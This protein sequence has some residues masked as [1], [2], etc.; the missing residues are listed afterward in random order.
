VNELET[1]R[2]IM[3]HALPILT[4][5][6]WPVTALLFVGGLMFGTRKRRGQEEE[7]QRKRGNN[8]RD[9]GIP[10]RWPF[11][12]RRIAG[13]AEREL[14]HWLCQVFPEH[15]V[16]IKV[17]LARFLVPSDPQEAR[18]WVRILPGVYC[19]FAVCTEDGYVIGC[20]DLI[21]AAGLPHGNRLIKQ[22]LLA[23]CGIGYRTVGQGQE[24][25]SDALRADFLGPRHAS[26]NPI[27]SGSE[28]SA[29]SKSQ[30]IRHARHRLHETLD[31]NRE[32]RD[33]VHNGLENPPSDMAPVSFLT[34]LQSQR[35]ALGQI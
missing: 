12:R 31:R 15:H 20:V 14:W 13:A 34:Q 27:N 1:E 19:T 18:E 28:N 9:L 16:I 35:A 29:F 24:I 5:L 32:D 33:S 3:A 6:T 10:A 21:G 4:W 17:P 2:I 25:V 22:T 30:L 11:A 23:Q 8:R 7:P 26:D